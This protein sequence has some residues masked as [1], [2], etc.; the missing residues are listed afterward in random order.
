MIS[1]MPYELL[2][3]AKSNGNGGVPKYRLDDAAQTQ[4]ICW[5]LIYANRDRSLVFTRLQGMLDGNAPFDHGELVSAGQANR[6]N[7]NFR[8]GAA[9]LAQAET[10]YYDLFAE[11]PTYF[12]VEV[13]EED[14]EKRNRYSQTV[15]HKFD[16]MLKAWSGFDWNV[17]RAVHDMVAFGPGFVMWPDATTWMFTAIQQSKV[18]VPDGTPSDP[19]QLELLVIRQELPV[20]ELYRF[21]RDP[22][23]AAQVGW[24]VTTTMQA[25]MKA[26]P[27]TVTDV[28]TY[29]YERWQ[30]QLRNHD[31]YDS[32]RSDVIKI[33]HV[34]VKEFSG[35]ISHLIVEERNAV[36]QRARPTL[37]KKQKQLKTDFLFK[38]FERYNCFR[39]V[40]NPFFYSIGNGTWHSIKGL[41]VELYP[42]IE[43]NNR[44]N[45]SIVD[46]AFINLSVLMQATSGRSEQ[47]TAL[48]QL[49]NLT[50]LPANMEIRQ[51][52][53]AGRMEEALAT[54]RSFSQKLENNT[55]QFRRTMRLSG[56]PETA[57]GRTIDEQK[58]ASLNKSAVNRFYAQ[59]DNLAL[60][61]YRRAT[62]FNLVPERDGRG[63]N[64]MA[65]EFQRKCLDAGV[66]KICMKKIRFVR[67]TRNTGN[68][69]V[70]LRQQTILQTASLSPMFNEQGKQNW[71]DDSIAVLAGAENVERWNPKQNL[72]PNLQNER[73]FAMLENSALADGSP[74]MMTSTQNDFIHATTHMQAAT[75]ALN[76]VPEGGDPMRVLGFLEVV[77]QHTALHVQRI[78]T[79]PLRKQEAGIL[80]QQLKQLA[81]HTDQLRSQLQQLQQQQMAEMQKRQ[82]MMARQAE[83]TQ[84]VM[85]DEQLRQYE[86][87]NKVQLSREKANAQMQM[88]EDRHVQEIDLKQQKAE[89]DLL[90]KDAT[91]AA[92]IRTKS[93]KTQADIINSTKKVDSAS[94]ES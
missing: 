4:Q 9:I 21:I 54:E 70:F 69:S 30:E 81:Q 76:S 28:S 60:E 83:K 44:L 63:P 11:S 75:E 22:K 85:T 46:N 6:T 77:G 31:L 57:T 5:T 48:M 80:M 17:Q 61:V 32:V 55:G 8:E 33:C 94:K 50:I 2:P 41:G 12:Q 16:D 51:W 37:Q 49:G 39:E 66:P 43:I 59:L 64:S 88:K 82:E 27:S 25:I 36:E 26:A 52:G 14:N 13:E 65:I 34:Y 10:P 71:L 23:V 24:N 15:T 47:E 79:D 89:M 1:E 35:K 90:V 3:L 74:V 45:C 87:V 78:S 73:A 86:T 42:F 19:E 53:L 7:V 56:N 62:N 92:D 40:I 67:A 20:C 18:L 58:Q 29:D 38:R 72:S 93:A 84:Q 91:T 68:G